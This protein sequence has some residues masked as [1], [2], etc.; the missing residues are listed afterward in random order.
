[1]L[2]AFVKI[3]SSVRSSDVSD[4]SSRGRNSSR[5]EASFLT[6][7]L[8]SGI[9]SSVGASQASCK[10]LLPQTKHAF[11]IQFCT[12]EALASNHAP[13]IN[14]TAINRLIF[15]SGCSLLVRVAM[16]INSIQDLF[17]MRQRYTTLKLAITPVSMGCKPAVGSAAGE[18]F[19]TRE[20]GHGVVGTTII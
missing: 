3:A 13:R 10:S 1:M 11:L 2:F 20:L 8:I 19:H 7:D 14:C 12:V 5:P 16:S 18:N 17:R 15:K 4:V 6:M 9:T